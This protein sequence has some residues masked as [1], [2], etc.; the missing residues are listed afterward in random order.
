MDRR[1]FVQLGLG[2]VA[3]TAASGWAA[4]RD[5]SESTSKINPKEL[6]ASEFHSARK[7]INTD[8]GRIAYVDRGKGPG[9]LFLHGFPL[10]SFQ[11]RGVIP[12]LSEHRRCIAPDFM[13]LGYTEVAK[14]QSVAPASQVAMIAQLLDKL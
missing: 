12:R 14:G 2:A 5:T 9:A 4:D 11:W 8:Q 13:G 10:N 6:S 7:F 3:A 1:Q